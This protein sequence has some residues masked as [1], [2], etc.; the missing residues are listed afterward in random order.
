VF[1]NA[2]ACRIQEA[3]SQF[4]ILPRAKR[5][6]NIIRFFRLDNPKFGVAFEISRNGQKVQRALMLDKDQRQG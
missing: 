6:W 1:R 2:R 4:I 3:A 5:V